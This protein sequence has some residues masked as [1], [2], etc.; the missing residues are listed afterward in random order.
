M[1]NEHTKKNNSFTLELTVVVKHSM[2][3]R[4]GTTNGFLYVP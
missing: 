3:L 4:I 1:N 2:G